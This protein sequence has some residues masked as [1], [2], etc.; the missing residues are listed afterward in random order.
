MNIDLSLEATKPE[1]DTH[2]ETPQTYITRLFLR[3][4][5]KIKSIFLYICES[6]DLRTVTEINIRKHII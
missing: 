3:R 6:Y 1:S 5:L 4:L 2:A